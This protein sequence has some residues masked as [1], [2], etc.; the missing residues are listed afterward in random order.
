MKTKTNIFIFLVYKI[1]QL[2]P[3]LLIWVL[4][5]HKLVKEKLKCHIKEGEICD[6]ERK[7]PG[8]SGS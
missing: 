8:L 4:Y 2:N 6:G 1:L 3:Y 5:P 7:T